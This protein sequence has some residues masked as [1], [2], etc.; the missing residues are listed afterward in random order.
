MV[1]FISCSGVSNSD[2]TRRTELY[3][4][5]DTPIPYN[6]SDEESHG[7]DVWPYLFQHLGRVA[8][9]SDGSAEDAHD[10]I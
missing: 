2:D 8:N 5:N 7:S 4:E 1:G 6:K 3:T 10:Q 9:R